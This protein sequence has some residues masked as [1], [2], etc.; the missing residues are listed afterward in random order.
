MREGRD[1]EVEHQDARDDQERV[2]ATHPESEVGALHRVEQCVAL[3]QHLEG[4]ALSDQPQVD[5]GDE[6]A[7]PR[8]EL[9]RVRQAVRPRPRV[10]SEEGRVSAEEE[11][12]EGGE[13]GGEVAREHAVE[14]GHEHLCM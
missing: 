4:D 10:E 11:K 6:R 12:D 5:H 7:V 9:G 13:K 2:V 3:G 1:E 8:V 14:R